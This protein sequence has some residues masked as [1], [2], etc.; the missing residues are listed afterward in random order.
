MHKVS[1]IL[2]K[3]NVVFSLM[4]TFIK[5]VS[6]YASDKLSFHNNNSHLGQH[7]MYLRNPVTMFFLSTKIFALSTFIL[8]LQ[9]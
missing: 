4:V 1:Q 7:M 3:Y 9:F 8:H 6:P 2:H 5:C